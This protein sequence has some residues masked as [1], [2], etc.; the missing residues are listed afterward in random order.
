MFHPALGKIYQ[1]LQITVKGQNLKA[2]DSF[3]YLGSNLSHT[4][5]IDDEINNRIT[6]ASAAFGRLR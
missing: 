5:N 1:E 2:V 6:K 4:A 3:T